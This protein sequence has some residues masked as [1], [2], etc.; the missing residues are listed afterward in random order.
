MYAAMD[1]HTEETITAGQNEMQ[2]FGENINVCHSF[3]LCL[4]GL[5]LDDYSY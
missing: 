4:K 2:K 5:E 3:Y 1:V